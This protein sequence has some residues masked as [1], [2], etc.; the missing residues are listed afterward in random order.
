MNR[1]RPQTAGWRAAAC[2]LLVVSVLAVPPVASDPTE[3]NPDAA[4][5]DPD[6]AAGKQAMEKKNWPE[7]AKRFQQA[8]L[9]D[10]ENAD[11]QKSGKGS[12]AI[13]GSRWSRTIRE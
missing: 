7:A 4:A 1:H 10:P 9:R 5:R 8:A 3:T 6:Y 12:Q 13:W 11:L 2:A